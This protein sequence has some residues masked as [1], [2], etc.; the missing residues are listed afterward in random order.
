MLCVGMF[1]LRGVDERMSRTE[2]GEDEGEQG[3]GT[4]RRTKGCPESI[5]LK[6]KRSDVGRICEEWSRN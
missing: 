6:L 2:E 4:K 5:F 1:D 3:S